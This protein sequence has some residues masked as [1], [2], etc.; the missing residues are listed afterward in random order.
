MFT[1]RFIDVLEIKFNFHKKDM[2][3][4]KLIKLALQNLMCIIY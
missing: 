4:F 3:F 1:L 2:Q